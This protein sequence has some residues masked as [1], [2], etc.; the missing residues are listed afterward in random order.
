MPQSFDQCSL[1]LHPAHHFSLKEITPL[2]T[3][4][5]KFNFIS[6]AINKQADHGYFAGD[7]FLDYIAYMGCAPSIQFEASEN[8]SNFCFIKIH[9][10]RP[11]KLIHSQKQARAPHCPN[12]KKPVKNWQ[13]ARSA[14]SIKCDQCETTSNIESFNWRKMAGYA[15]LFIE[16]TDIFPKEAIPQ[17]ILLDKL[18][19][20]TGVEWT[21]FYSCR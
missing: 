18:A 14:T 5:Q 10:Y 19:D 1:Y 3:E 12:C 7:K 20:I 9:H 21:Y 11:A 15:Q 8:S 16:I 17:Q 4:L 13:D 2:I 6:Q